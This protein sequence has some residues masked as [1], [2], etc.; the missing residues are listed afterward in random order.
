MEADRENEEAEDD[1]SS[2]LY[3]ED[4]DDPEPLSQY[5]LLRKRNIKRNNRVLQGL[6]FKHAPKARKNVG[7]LIPYL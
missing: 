4:E 5:E 2:E 6:G 1:D 3:S 7:S